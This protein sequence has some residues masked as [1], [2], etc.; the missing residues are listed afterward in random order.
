M[1]VVPALLDN[2]P[3]NEDGVGGMHVYVPWWLEDEKLDFVRGYHIEPWGGRQMPSYGFLRGIQR[4][5]RK[6][7]DGT[8]RPRGGGGYGVQLKEDYRRLY[9]AVVGFSGRG[10]MIARRDNRCT[11]D[12]Y[13]VDQYGIPVLRFDVTWSDQEYAQVKHMQET[14]RSIIYAMGGEPTSSMPSRDEGYGIHPPGQIIHE[15]GTTRMGHDPRTSV[16]NK[17]CQAH[18]AKNV[19]VADGGPLVSQAHKNITWTILALAWRASEY[20]I[21][22]RKRGNI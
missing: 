21:E 17:W 22:E 8:I 6:N 14:M 13:Q 10:E 7:A 4:L 20:I 12:P 1:G 16:L 18:D 9:G 3:H 11:I 15:G 2:L 19:F 5:N